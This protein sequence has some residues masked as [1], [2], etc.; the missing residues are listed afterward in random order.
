MSCW[1]PKINS[2]FKHLQQLLPSFVLRRI[3]VSARRMKLFMILE[4]KQI[5]RYTPSNRDRLAQLGRL[6]QLQLC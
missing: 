6:A 5:S 3:I 4:M 1:I 2:M